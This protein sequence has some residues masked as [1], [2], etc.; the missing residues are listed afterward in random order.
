[1][2]HDHD[3]ARRSDYNRAFAI[4]VA[5]NV[6][7][8]LVEAGYGFFAGSLALLADAG[9]NL[10]D[11]VSLLLAWG[12]AL[13][14][15][16]R[17]TERRTY[18]FRRATILAAL[19]SAV[20]LLVA[21]GAIA[22]EALG[23]LQAPVAVSGPVVI[24]VAAIGVV[25]NTIT[26]LLFLSRRKSDLNIKGA[27]LHMAADAVVSLGVV[28]A[29]IG[30]MTLGWLWLDPAVGLAIVGIILL[31][32]WGLFRDSFN[33]AVDAVPRDIDLAEVRGFLLGRPGV[34]DVHDLHVWGLST[35]QVALTAH[36][37]VS[38]RDGSRSLGD[39]FLPWLTREL[40]HRFGIGHATIQVESDNPD[41]P[42][43]RDSDECL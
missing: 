35:T 34:C 10:S 11:V 30:M 32:S 23:R 18:G 12:A 7:F 9:H 19:L 31:A 33:L 26:A 13:L 38:F 14:A 3:P 43:E 36:L 29:G 40:S 16:S 21:L 42:C 24:L 8:V 37:V 6:V 2:S 41:F 28:V 39:E 5:L 25:I 27:F 1:M 4:G 15:S 17:P 22:W 20:L